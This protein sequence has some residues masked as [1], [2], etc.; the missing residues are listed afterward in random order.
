[1]AKKNS[2]VV[3]VKKD[4]EKISN[5]KKKDFVK[6]FNKNIQSKFSAGP[7]K[8]FKFFEWGHSN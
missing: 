4:F 8:F 7:L 1:L 3:A 2:S 5:L 6:I